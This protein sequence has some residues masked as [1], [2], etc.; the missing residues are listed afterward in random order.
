MIFSYSKNSF[1]FTL[2]RLIEEENICFHG[3]FSLEGTTSIMTLVIFK[4]GYRI[5]N[6]EPMQIKNIMCRI[7]FIDC[8]KFYLCPNLSFKYIKG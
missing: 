1:I 3:T 5:K 8:I 2:I 4:K 7:V 6:I